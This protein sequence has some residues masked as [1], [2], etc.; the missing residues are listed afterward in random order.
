MIN[1]AVSV[2]ADH[3]ANLQDID[4]A[5]IMGA[6]HPIGPLKLADL[7]GLDICL[8]I[9]DTLYLETGNA[10]YSA[11]PLLRK[12]VRGNK[13]GVKTNEGFYNY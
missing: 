13:L 3:T 6:N 4:N 2:L 12:M 7:I 11:H 5:M 8:S 1:E 10:K 9:L